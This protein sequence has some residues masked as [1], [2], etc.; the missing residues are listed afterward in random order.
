MHLDRFGVFTCKFQFPGDFV[1]F[2]FYFFSALFNR[3]YLRVFAEYVRY[4][5]F[6]A[7]PDKFAIVFNRRTRNRYGNLFRVNVAVRIDILCVDIGRTDEFFPCGDFAARFIEHKQP[8][9]RFTFERT[10]FQLSVLVNFKFYS[11]RIGVADA[12]PFVD[13]IEVHRIDS[14]FFAVYFRNRIYF[15]VFDYVQCKTH[16]HQRRVEIFPFAFYDNV[17]RTRLF[18]H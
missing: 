1:G 4:G 11:R 6:I 10:G 16:A 3:T 13:D 8:F 7:F 15:H 5:K 14:A 2:E 17:S 18:R 9:F 12:L